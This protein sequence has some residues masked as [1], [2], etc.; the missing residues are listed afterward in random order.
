MTISALPPGPRSRKPKSVVQR[1][2][3]GPSRDP[4]AELHEQ[5][6]TQLRAALLRELKQTWHGLNGSYFKDRLQAPAFALSD[7]V[8]RLGQWD[9]ETRTLSVSA[10]MVLERPWGTVVEVLKHEIAH[11]YVHEIA[12]AGSET[13]HG[14]TFRALCRRLGIDARAAGFAPEEPRQRDVDAAVQDDRI[15]S[16]I[17]KLLALAESDSVNEA[18]A[19]MSAAQR[20][21]LKYNLESVQ[22]EEA[23]RG[24][25]YRHLG[26]ATGRVSEAERMIAVVLAEHFFVEIIWVPVYRPLEGKR[27]SILEACG[28][29]ANLEMASYVYD[30]L[31]HAGEQLWREHKK[32][33]GLKGNRDRRTFLA[34]VMAGFHAKL[35]AQRATQRREGLVWAGDADLK[36][37]Y[38]RRHP[39]IQHTRYTGNRRTEAHGHGRA[40]GSKLVLHRPVTSGASG[41]GPKLLRG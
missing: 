27:G 19:A 37:Y 9:P 28:T 13:P 33:H 41:G 23:R 7:T 25:G 21:M 35:V 6:S 15:L 30:F 39:H 36:G 32:A 31:M 2:A 20:L 40:A 24:Y 5:L 4:E 34:G 18:H 38:R 3:T 17:A 16:R 22:I 11:Q 1:P 26:R 14:P 29:P 8:T 12:D 10:R